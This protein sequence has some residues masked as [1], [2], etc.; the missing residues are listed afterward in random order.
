MTRKP[1]FAA[2]AVLLSFAVWA[3][4]RVVSPLSDGEPRTGEWNTHFIATKE[5]ADREALPMLVYYGSA[6]CGA[7]GTF[8]EAALMGGQVRAWLS[9]NPVLLVFL[10][11]DSDA[12]LSAHMA[13]SILESAAPEFWAANHWIKSVTPGLHQYP[14]VGLY[15]AKPDGTKVQRA[16]TGRNGM[17]PRVSGARG[18]ED[19]LLELLKAD[20]AGAASAGDPG[21]VPPTSAGKV[22]IGTL[23]TYD[24]QMMN[25]FLCAAR[26]YVVPL[27][28]A[29]E[30][31]MVSCGQA[32]VRQTSRNKLTVKLECAGSKVAT[33][34]GAWSTID[35]ADG[36]ADATVSKGDTT[37]SL[38]LSPDGVMTVS[39]RHGT[40]T[41]SVSCAGKPTSEFAHLAGNYTAAAYLEG[42][43]ESVGYLTIAVTRAG[44]A[45][46]KGVFADGRSISGSSRL[47]SG[48][49]GSA[50][51]TIYKCAAKVAL[52]ASLVIASE[53]DLSASG[54]RRGCTLSCA[55]GTSAL[56]VNDALPD[57]AHSLNI[58]GGVH[59]KTHALGEMCR[60]AGLSNTL[61]VQVGG[62][63]V[64]TVTVGKSKFAL[65]KKD[66]VTAISYASA[67]GVFTGKAR[68]QVQGKEVSGSFCGVVHSGWGDPL[69]FGTGLF[70]AKGVILPLALVDAPR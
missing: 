5:K 20:F 24:L 8:V 53:G 65:S 16:F 69:V 66:A 42:T 17:M 36:Q 39:D 56:C 31:R 63:A 45:T 30:G 10:N 38:T 15:W 62:E 50:Q 47:T 54:N 27:F 34:G 2:V 28:Q 58:L 33:L 40:L 22:A 68:V 18:L 55:K 44:R 32:T 43:D 7:S 25:G 21:D 6:G 26:E 64:G 35:L 4:E 12:E 60:E 3:Q 61:Q 67:T 51:L 37:L 41:G 29:V 48:G 57:S 52:A 9:E 70:Y 49:G 23:S 59:V 11:A 14:F 19:C 46:W 1:A 13:K